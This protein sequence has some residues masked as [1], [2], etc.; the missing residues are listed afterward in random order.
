MKSMSRSISCKS[1]GGDTTQEER[2]GRKMSDKDIEAIKA[3]SAMGFCFTM[4][5]LL[6]RVVQ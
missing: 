3:V 2:E 1:P 5:Y 4:L 6:M